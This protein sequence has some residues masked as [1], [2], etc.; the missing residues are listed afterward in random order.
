MSMFVN[1][2]TS[3]AFQTIAQN[4]DACVKIETG[5]MQKESEYILKNFFKDLRKNGG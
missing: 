4:T 5:I 1:L 3:N 2:I